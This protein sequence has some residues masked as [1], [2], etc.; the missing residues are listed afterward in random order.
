MKLINNNIKFKFNTINQHNNYNTIL[1][2]LTYK[3]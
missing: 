1:N 3:Y 2:N